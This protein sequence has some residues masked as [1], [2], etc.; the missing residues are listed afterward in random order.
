MCDESGF[1]HW[2][3]LSFDELLFKEKCIVASSSSCSECVSCGKVF[4]RLLCYFL[5]P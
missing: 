1:L 5:L 4:F 3:L 2:D